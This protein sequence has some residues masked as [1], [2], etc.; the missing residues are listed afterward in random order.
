MGSDPDD[1]DEQTAFGLVGNGG[2]LQVGDDAIEQ[3]D[4]KIPAFGREESAKRR[5]DI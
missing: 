5:M 1:G 4:Q 3:G 2:R